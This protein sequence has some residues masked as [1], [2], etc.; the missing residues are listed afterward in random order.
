MLLRKPTKIAIC[1]NAPTVARALEQKQQLL[2][3]ESEFDIEWDIRAE[4]VE[5]TVASFSQIIN[6][7]VLIVESE[8]MILINPATDPTPEDVTTIV[9]ELCNGYAVSHIVA[10]GFYGL[11]KEVF[12]RIGMMDER[13][14][15]GGYEDN[16]F[17][18]RLKQLDVAISWRYRSNQYKSWILGNAEM[19]QLQN[20]Y[21]GITS[22]V[23]PI[24]W[25]KIGST[26]YR[27]D[28]FLKEK[29]APKYILNK[30]KQGIYESWKPWS[31]SLH[32]KNKYSVLFSKIDKYQI[33]SKIAYSRVNKALSTLTLSIFNKDGTDKYSNGIKLAHE[34]NLDTTLIIAI[35]DKNKQLLT[36]YIKLRSNT[37][38]ADNLK[39]DLF[40]IR[41]F[42]N[43][44]IVLHNSS[45]KLD[46]E[47]KYTLGLDVYDFVIK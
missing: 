14:I 9:E 43:G 27:T 46:T 10:F 36:Q 4:R 8:F 5:G 34:S 45:Y 23:F 35:C 29:V 21:T 24:K 7:S 13:F 47:E 20:Q 32:E 38:H 3:L 41:V 25:H 44:R 28:L 19:P 17:L 42:H 39:S 18:I 15:G 40:D 16:D 22:T 11:T 37:W 2:A 26:L 30:P 6:E 12:R 33:S 31:Q 1:L